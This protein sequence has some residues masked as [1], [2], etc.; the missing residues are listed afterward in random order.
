MCVKRTE[1][2]GE[3][4]KVQTRERRS[5]KQ[6]EKENGKKVSNVLEA[7]ECDHQ[8]RPFT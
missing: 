8:K 5:E 3:E 7:V 4:G 2:L 6:K 1:L